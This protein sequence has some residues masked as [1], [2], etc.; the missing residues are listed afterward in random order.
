MTAALSSRTNATSAVQLPEVQLAPAELHCSDHELSGEA[1]CLVCCSSLQ[2]RSQH[3]LLLLLL[4]ATVRRLQAAGVP[5]KC[6]VTS[7]SGVYGWHRKP[8]LWRLASATTRRSVHAAAFA[9]ASAMRTAPAHY[10]RQ[11]CQR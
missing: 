6:S 2:A 4:G 10:A 1:E 8:K 11:S 3:T 9:C 5:V 7:T